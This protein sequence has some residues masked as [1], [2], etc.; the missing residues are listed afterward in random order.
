MSALPS[1]IIRHPL[2]AVWD[3]LKA[4]GLEEVARHEG[5]RPA[6]RKMF[7]VQHF[8]VVYVCRDMQGKPTLGTDGKP[9][10]RWKRTTKSDDADLA[11][12]LYLT[13]GQKPQGSRPLMVSKD[14]VLPDADG[15]LYLVEGFADWLSMLAGGLKN[16]V[17]IFGGTGVPDDIA[18]QAEGIGATQIVMFVHPDDAGTHYA[19]G[20]ADKCAG[21]SIIPVF[22]RLPTDGGNK[23]D[24]ND[25]W[26]DCRFDKDAFSKRLAALEA[27][28]LAPTVKP[29]YKPKPVVATD[30]TPERIQQYLKP[31]LDGVLAD[32]GKVASGRNNALTAAAARVGNFVGAGWISESEAESQ[33]LGVALSIGLKEREALATIRSGLKLGATTPATLSERMV[34][35]S[36]SVEK[37]K[38]RPTPSLPKAPEKSPIHDL[39]QQ[40][41]SQVF[42]RGLPYM[43][44]AAIGLT[45]GSAA[46]VACS[47]LIN[48]ISNGFITEPFEVAQN[49]GHPTEEL[50][51]SVKSRT[52]QRWIKVLI[53]A[54][55]LVCKNLDTYIYKNTSVQNF[56]FTTYGDFIAKIASHP[57]LKRSLMMIY[58][59]ANL[60]E[61][62]KPDPLMFNGEEG[63]PD[64]PAFADEL[65]GYL[66]PGTEMID[67][68][69]T[70]GNYCVQLA[71]AYT[72]PPYPLDTP[73]EL[74]TIDTPADYDALIWRSYATGKQ[75]D[76][77]TRWKM[78]R[79]IGCTSR[80]TIAN[81]RKRA[82]VESVENFEVVPINHK[83]PN[84]IK[85]VWNVLTSK[86]HY[87]L[88]VQYTDANGKPRSIFA[89][90][91]IKDEKVLQRLQGAQSIGVKVQVA[92]TERLIS[93]EKTAEPVQAA[94]PLEQPNQKVLPAPKKRA[95]KPKGT[96]WN[97][98]VRSQLALA[99]AIIEH[100]KAD[101]RY[102]HTGDS[103]VIAAATAK[104]Q[105]GG[106]SSA[107]LLEMIRQS[108]LVSSDTPTRA[109]LADFVL[110]NGGMV[111]EV[112]RE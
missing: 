90:V 83:S 72:M 54:G 55:L 78:A 13:A 111:T 23:R 15:T 31:A 33:L 12:D 82:G 85:A 93:A 17:G 6:P 9:L 35:Q 32:L 44:Y 67:A 14:G 22:Y 103:R 11:K 107:E 41:A 39:M 69:A 84:A 88:A 87:P 100:A 63:A 24:V 81:A 29:E 62:I 38:E 59:N 4:R 104:A 49:F 98:A 105:H 25:L 18:A 112:T 48:A 79:L 92:S 75:P 95:S 76:R 5:M 65:L 51:L 71:R 89:P 58:G 21:S 106:K 52:F 73:D 94:L 10:E 47:I 60:G 108:Q 68:S 91:A 19:Q 99:L 57:N 64:D 109:L 101:P 74:W 43:V 110:T 46:K 61:L 53:D 3:A 86:E 34:K 2:L 36:L 50:G 40:P 27:F 77:S 70:F 1:N 96:R 28:T 66:P 97:A 20:L 37:P 26:I 102:A 7:G 30:N 16:T 45:Y 42:K 56:A 8:G 80:S